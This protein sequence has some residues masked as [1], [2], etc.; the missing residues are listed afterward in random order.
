MCGLALLWI[1]K[2]TKPYSITFPLMVGLIVLIRMSFSKFKIFTER[3]LSWLDDCISEE[4]KDEKDKKE[5]K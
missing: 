2:K 4:E 3:E 1:I 5:E